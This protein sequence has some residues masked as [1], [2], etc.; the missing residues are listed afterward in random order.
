MSDTEKKPI[1]AV[2]KYLPY[3]VI[4]LENFKNSKGQD[5]K[6]KKVMALCR[7][8]HSNN[9]PYCDGSHSKVGFVGEKDPERVPDKIDEYEGRNIIIIDN[10]G[11]C[12]HKGACTDNLPKVFIPYDVRKGKPWIDPNN[13]TVKAIIET[14]EKCPSGALSYKIGKRRYQDLERQPLIIVS[15]DG[16]LEVVGGIFLKD[17]AESKAESKEHY[18]LCRCGESLN[19]PFCDG[20]HHDIEFKDEKN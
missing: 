1:I 3:L 10:R 7:C 19:K 4:D 9:K 17:D 12:A 15:K 20:T 2:V 8:G 18:C 14:I 5:L 16:P 11:V 13:A 6:I